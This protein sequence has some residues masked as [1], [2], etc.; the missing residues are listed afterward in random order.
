MPQPQT[1]TFRLPETNPL[2]LHPTVPWPPPL[3]SAPEASM[4]TGPPRAVR[5][6]P[7]HGRTH[8]QQPGTAEPVSL[9]FRV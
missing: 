9:G 3:S 5:D 6:A 7:R 4:P 8:T 2:P 1:L